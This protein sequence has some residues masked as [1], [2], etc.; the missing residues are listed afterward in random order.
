M[1]KIFAYKIDDNNVDILLD[2]MSLLSLKEKEYVCRYKYVKDQLRSLTGRLMLLAFADRYTDE[3]YKEI[4]YI[5]GT[6]DFT[7]DNMSDISIVV[8]ENGKGRIE[9]TPHLLKSL[10]RQ[11]WPRPHFTDE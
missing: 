8:D 2:K 1:I 10:V 11:E 7:K 4:N 3:C 6:D 5:S 9:N